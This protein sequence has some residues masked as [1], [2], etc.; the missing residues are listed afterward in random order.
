MTETEG[1]MDARRC[2]VLDVSTIADDDG[3]RLS[4]VPVFFV[5]SAT[6]HHQWR[7]DNCMQLAA[8]IRYVSHLQMQRVS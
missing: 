5:R 4:A 7:N 8:N 6:K 1:V 3:I 2:L